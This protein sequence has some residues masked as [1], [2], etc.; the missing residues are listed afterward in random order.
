[1]TTSPQ[2]HGVAGADQGVVFG[3]PRSWLGLEA[4]V[5]LVGVVIAYGVLGQSWWLVPVGIF[6]PDLA[7]GGYLAGNRLGAHVYNVAHA[8]PM[9]ALMLGFGYWQADRLVSALALIWLAHIA[10]DR[11]LGYGLKY[12]DRFT[13]T[14][15]SDHH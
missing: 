11:L 8:M 7:M 15:L 9:P 3:P 12:S 13:H 2:E 14:H 6:V 10:L 4:L 1:M 5:L